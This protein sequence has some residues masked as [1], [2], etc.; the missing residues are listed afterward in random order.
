M[1]CLTDA[2]EKTKMSACSHCFCFECIVKWTEVTNC[3]PLCKVPSLSLH[4][5]GNKQ[6]TR[7]NGATYIKNVIIDRI[8]IK[9]KKQTYNPDDPGNLVPDF[10]DV[11]YECGDCGENDSAL[12][13]C[14]H[15]D[16][17]VCHFKCAGF[18]AV[19]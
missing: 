7:S 9:H 5:F 13:V 15:C 2:V 8:R 19:P 16:Y 17:K 12:I 3:C 11:C 6:F 1:I 4:R 18:S 14:D 10:A